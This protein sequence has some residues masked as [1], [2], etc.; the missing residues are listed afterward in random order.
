MQE[1]PC[2]LPRTYVLGCYQEPQVL[3]VPEQRIARVSNS[4]VLKELTPS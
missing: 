1:N 2:D 4:L 3:E